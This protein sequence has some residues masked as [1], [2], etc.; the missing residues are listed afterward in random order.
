MLNHAVAGAQ[1]PVSIPASFCC[2]EP[3]WD[4]FHVGG[5]LPVHFHD[6]P[7]MVSEFTA[8]ALSTYKSLGALPPRLFTLSSLSPLI[9]NKG[10]FRQIA[11]AV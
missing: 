10:S 9:L 8:S 3:V 11:H 6:M 1:L 7:S 4:T 2:V 5:S